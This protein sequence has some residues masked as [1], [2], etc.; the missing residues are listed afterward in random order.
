MSRNKKYKKE[1]NLKKKLTF[2][3]DTKEKVKLF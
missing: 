1:D 3:E 2:T